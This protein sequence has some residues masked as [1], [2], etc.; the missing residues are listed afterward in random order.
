MEQILTTTD[1]YS[2]I[3]D[4]TIKGEVSIEKNAI[5]YI[6]DIKVKMSTVKG[7]TTFTVTQDFISD[8][9]GKEFNIEQ[10]YFVIYEDACNGAETYENYLTRNDVEDN[11]FAKAHH[12]EHKKTYAKL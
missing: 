9:I 11:K 7:S 6:G 4:Y 10:F 12:N 3:F 1:N 2:N 5:K 8:Y